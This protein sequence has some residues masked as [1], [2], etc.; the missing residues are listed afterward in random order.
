MN[1]DSFRL[2]QSRMAKNQSSETSAPI[3][4]A[5][6]Q[7]ALPRV[8]YMGSTRVKARRRHQPNGKLFRR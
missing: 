1:G 3:K 4:L 7:R 8:S 5:C 2:R 6:G